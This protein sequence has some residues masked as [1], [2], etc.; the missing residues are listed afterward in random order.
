MSELWFIFGEY[1][2]GF[3]DIQDEDGRDIMTHVERVEA[4]EICERHNSHWH[5]DCK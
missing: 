5:D 2:C 1:K 3:V 4:E